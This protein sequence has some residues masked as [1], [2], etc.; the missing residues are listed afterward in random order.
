MTSKDRTQN[1]HLA[2]DKTP[3]WNVISFGAISIMHGSRIFFWGSNVDNDPFV[4]F[5]NQQQQQQQQ[6]QHLFANLVYMCSF[7]FFT[8]G[9]G[10]PVRLFRSLA[11]DSLDDPMHIHENQTA[12][13]NSKKVEI[14]PILIHNNSTAKHMFYLGFFTE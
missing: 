11:L 12:L 14:S 3:F 4:F 1:A 13:P 8:V 7:K 5:R 9:K 6:Q 2:Y 10:H